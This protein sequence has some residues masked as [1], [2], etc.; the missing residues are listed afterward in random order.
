MC[1][2][3]NHEM[4]KLEA[5]IAEKQQKLEELK[6]QHRLEALQ[7]PEFKLAILLHDMTCKWNH[8]DG[9]SWYYEMV[10]HS[11]GEEHNWT[12]WAHDQFLRKARL[13]IKTPS[14]QGIELEQLIKILGETQAI[15]N[16][17]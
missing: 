9:C 17:R 3:C 10:K 7:A 4:K 6:E 12:G 13:I 1:T 11:K 2:N 5:E 14:L 8:T 16:A 15:L